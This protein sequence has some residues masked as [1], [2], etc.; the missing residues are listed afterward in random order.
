VNLHSEIDR[1]FELQ[2]VHYEII[3]NT[4]ADQRIEK[5]RRLQKSIFANQSVI[6]TALR[7]DLNKAP[8]E[9]GLSE[10]YPVLSEIRHACKHLR[11]WMEPR[12]LKNPLVFFRAEASIR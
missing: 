6:E 12:P 7:E 10:L 2:K 5:L 11:V 9:A 1:V 4:S 8:Q 3:R